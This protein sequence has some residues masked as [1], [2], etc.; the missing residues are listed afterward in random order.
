MV[1]L[2]ILLFAVAFVVVVLEAWAGLIATEPFQQWVAIGAGALVL[3]VI[4]SFSFFFFNRPTGVA[5]D[6]KGAR[7]IHWLYIVA[8]RVVI[9]GL[10]FI[11]PTQ[12]LPALAPGRICTNAACTIIEP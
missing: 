1:G 7:L 12:V 3:A 11:L 8:A 9:S 6:S 2:R 4:L 5:P 10:S